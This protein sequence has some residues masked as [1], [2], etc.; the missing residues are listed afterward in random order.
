MKGMTDLILAAL[1]LSNLALAGTSRLANAIAWVAFQGALVGLLP[2]FSHSGV[3]PRTV[4]LAVLVV[5]LKAVV[6]PRLLRHAMRDAEIRREVE[7]FV[8][9]GLS[10]LL[11]VALM[12][13][14]FWLG[15]ALPLPPG[16]EAG[17][18]VLP[19]AIGTILMG[20]FLTITRRKA[21]TQALGYLVIENGIA[22]FG[23]ALVPEIP[24]LVEL[25]ILLDVFFAV[26]VMAIVLYHIH[27]EFDHLD[28]DRLSV[29]RG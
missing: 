13:I 12:A 20:L 4:A 25:G 8:G 22:A 9:Y 29:L 5:G 16:R 10:L 21:V 17:W 24:L 26:L 2:L 23:L 18:L 28:A 19:G 1:L 7:P 6:Y 27:R 3:T 14:S 15:A 11:V